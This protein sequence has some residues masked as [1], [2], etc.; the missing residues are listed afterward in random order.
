MSGHIHLREEV[1]RADVFNR[2][3]A[4]GL[5]E[6]AALRKAAEAAAAWRDRP[7]NDQRLPPTF[8]RGWPI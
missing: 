8:A 3:L 6:Q 2:R 5:P 7:A 1:V 4:A